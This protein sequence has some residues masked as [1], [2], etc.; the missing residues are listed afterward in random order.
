MMPGF[1]P[2]LSIIAAGA[3]WGLAMAAVGIGVNDWR[4]WV[5]LAAYATGVAISG[6]PA[7]GRTR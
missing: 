4:F 2:R 1:G 7:R 6:T 3:I 5:L